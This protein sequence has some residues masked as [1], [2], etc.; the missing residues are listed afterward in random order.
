MALD[1]RYISK[2]DLANL[3]MHIEQD[4]LRENV[5]S[6]DQIAVSHGGFNRIEFH[7]NETYRLTP[8]VLSKPRIEM[9]EGSLMLFFTGIT[10]L[11]SDVAK[12]KVGNFSQR[13]K[14]LKRIEEMVDEAISVLNSKEG[15]L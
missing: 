1:G 6:Q 15:G 8:I 14:E 12:D 4:V 9:L 2:E 13:G 7:V 10:R 5:G 11:S 3:A